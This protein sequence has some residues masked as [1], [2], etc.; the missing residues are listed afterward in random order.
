MLSELKIIQIYA[1]RAL[2]KAELHVYKINLIRAMKA[3]LIGF[4]SVYCPDV[5]HHFER[6][7]NPIR[8]N[9]TIDDFIETWDVGLN[10]TESH[11]ESM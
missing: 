2:E 1:F 9:L 3:V 11:K 8:R 4:T 7:R 10:L 5:V 6:F